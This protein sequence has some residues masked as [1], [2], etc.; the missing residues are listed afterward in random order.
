MP[1]QLFV[2]YFML[3]FDNNHN[4]IFNV[5]QHFFLFLSVIE[6]THH[7]IGIPTSIQ[8]VSKGTSYNK[9]QLLGV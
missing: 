4:Y 9:V 8:L 7:C 6:V 2:G 1:Y 5:P 3:M